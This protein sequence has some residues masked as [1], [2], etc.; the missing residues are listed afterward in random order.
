[1][2]DNPKLRDEIEK[3]VRSHFGIAARPARAPETEAKA[4]EA[5]ARSDAVKAAVAPPLPGKGRAG[6]SRAARK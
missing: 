1:M 3:K 5:K 2:R 4:L 6:V